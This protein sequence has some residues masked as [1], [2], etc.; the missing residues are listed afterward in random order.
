MQLS[1]IKGQFVRWK[2]L[3]R[4]KDSDHSGCMEMRLWS[5]HRLPVIPNIRKRENVLPS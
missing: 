4:K 1:S 3:E 2:E 5:E